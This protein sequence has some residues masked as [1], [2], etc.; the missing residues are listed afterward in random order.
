MYTCAAADAQLDAFDTL[1]QRPLDRLPQA[2]AEL[3]RRLRGG[4]TSD[5]EDVVL[6][7]EHNCWPWP[8][9][10]LEKVMGSR[11]PRGVSMGYMRNASFEILR[12]VGSASTARLGDSERT[13]VRGDGVCEALRSRAAGGRWA[14]PNSGAYVTTLRGGRAMLERLRQLVLSGHFEDQGMAGLALLQ[15][16]RRS[17]VVDTNATLL[18]SQVCVY[19]AHMHA[20]ACR[21]VVPLNLNSVYLPIKQ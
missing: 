6:V 7:G 8:Q 10:E 18:S 19:R 4:E 5:G 1:V 3:T 17:L 16:P 15:H 9:P 11:R 14:F 20:D 12:D 2:F 21:H 13:V